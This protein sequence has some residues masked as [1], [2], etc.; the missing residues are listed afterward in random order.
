MRY[1]IYKESKQTGIVRYWN[2][3]EGMWSKWFSNDCY[4]DTERGVNRIYKKLTKNMGLNDVIGW[5]AMERVTA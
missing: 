1:Y 2:R 5:Q 4:Y 3:R